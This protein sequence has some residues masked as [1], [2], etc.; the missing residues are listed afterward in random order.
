M[1][2]NEYK[3][4]LFKGLMES[5]LSVHQVSQ[6]P[7]LEPVS[8]VLEVPWIDFFSFYLLQDLCCLVSSPEVL[9]YPQ[10]GLQNRFCL[11]CIPI[12][13]VTDT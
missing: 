6:T 1:T 7:Y 9:R 13:V 2:Q 5:D 12:F 8:P 10:S 3:I 11:Y 4:P